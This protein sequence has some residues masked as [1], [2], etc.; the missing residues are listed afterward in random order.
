MAWPFK[1]M[2]P[3]AISPH[4]SLGKVGKAYV[5]NIMGVTYYFYSEENRLQFQND[6]GKFEPAYGGWCAYAR[7]NT[8]EKV[9]IDPET[10][11]V[12]EG[13][14]YLFYNFYFNNTL[15]TWNQKETV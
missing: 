12:L 7:G 13:R 15:K 9:K 8:G 1:D 2:I 10:Y 11:K 14:L 6:P 4:K 3:L 5:T